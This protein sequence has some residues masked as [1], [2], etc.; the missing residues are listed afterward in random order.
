MSIKET[1]MFRF[2]RKPILLLGIFVLAL[3]ACQPANNP[4]KTIP[5]ADQCIT[6]SETFAYSAQQSFNEIS[7]I[8]VLPVC[9]S[10]ES[11]DY[12]L[13]LDR[14]TDGKLDLRIMDK[15]ACNHH[16]VMRDVS[17]SPEWSS[18]GKHIFIGCEQAQ[19]IC[20]L[21]APATLT[22]CIDNPDGRECTPVIEKIYALP[23]EIMTPTYIT[24]SWS[25]Y[26]DE[27]LVTVQADLPDT[28]VYF[29]SLEKGDWHLIGK[30]ALLSCD[31]SPV[32]DDLIC[33][34]IEKINLRK[35]FFEGLHVGNNP[36]WSP[37][38]EQ[39]VFVFYQ[40]QDQE[41]WAGTIMEWTFNAEKHWRILREPERSDQNNL[42]N[43]K[44]LF[45]IGEFS[46][47]PDKKYIAFTANYGQEF[48]SLIFRLDTY[49]GEIVVLT[50]K[51]GD[52]FYRSPVWG[53]LP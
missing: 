2:L 1:C 12:I 6:P 28:Y 36:T 30:N 4:L 14:R 25:A 27:L 45:N 26:G 41:D 50:A 39:I 3:P 13:F 22:P 51:I 35:N 8:E 20:V 19:G 17:G 23:D 53:Y 9:E 31:L 48:E 16:I 18:D 24:T 40:I 38:G 15:N 29:L 32:T 10:T 21:D 5:E 49:T 52:G 33:S 47:S 34:G 42:E 44:T 43:Q 37:D 11:R 46:W 7:T